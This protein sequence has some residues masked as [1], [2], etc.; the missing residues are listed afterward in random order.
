MQI[1]S[2]KKED[3]SQYGKTSTCAVF[4]VHIRVK[5]IPLKA[6]EMI[7]TISDRSWIS[8]LG[9]VEQAAYA[10]RANKTIRKI[11]KQILEKVENKVTEEFGEYLVTESARNAMGKQYRHH[12]GWPLENP[13]P[14]AGSKS[15]TFRWSERGVI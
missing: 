1:V 4:T 13:P 10:A 3:L 14:V 9:V 12:L 2:C 7:L 6:K 11:V 8:K 5:N 15:P